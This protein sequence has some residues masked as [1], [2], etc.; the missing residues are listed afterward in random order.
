MNVVEESPRNA[1]IDAGM[2]ARL[3]KSKPG[4]KIRALVLLNIPNVQ[5]NASGKRT[6]AAERASASR[7]IRDS[8]AAAV[9]SVDLIL[10]RFE[11][12]RLTEPSA[13]GTIAIESTPAGIK[14]ISESQDVRA[15]LEDQPVSRLRYA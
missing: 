14:A 1:R 3:A 12:R 11:G 4:Q 10:K 6:G 7:S 9:E 13:L 2:L 5:Q 15:I 8:S